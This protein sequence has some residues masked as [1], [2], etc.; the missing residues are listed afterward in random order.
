M[1]DGNNNL[2]DTGLD[3]NVSVLVLYQ[4]NPFT[5]KPIQTELTSFLCIKV[6]ATLLFVQ[7]DNLGFDF[8]VAN[9]VINH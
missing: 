6:V 5:K 3:Y 4:Q 7:E 2:K 1:R 8:Y 9:R